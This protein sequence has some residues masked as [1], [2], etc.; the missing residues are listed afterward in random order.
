M[1]LIHNFSLRTCQLKGL[2]SAPGALITLNKKMSIRENVQKKVLP[3]L[4]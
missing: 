3:S 2:K 1:H 4:L